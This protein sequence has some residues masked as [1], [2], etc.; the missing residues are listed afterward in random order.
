MKY[1]R[2]IT[3]DQIDARRR[4]TEAMRG[5]D[6]NPLRGTTTN[7]DLSAF[8]AIG[9]VYNQ[10]TKESEVWSWVKASWSFMNETVYIMGQSD[11]QHL[12]NDE[13]T[14]SRDH[15]LEKVFGMGL[16]EVESMM[17]LNDASLFSW[18]QMANYIDAETDRLEDAETDRLQEETNE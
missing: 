8:C 14:R 13:T 11:K 17:Y 16:S 15:D 3:K 6:D 1:R 18:K 10:L 5:R 9:M 7:K 2:M 12:T 4:L